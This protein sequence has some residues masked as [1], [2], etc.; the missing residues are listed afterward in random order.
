MKVSN[1]ILLIVSIY[2]I[3]SE[4]RKWYETLNY[5]DNEEEIPESIQHL[6]I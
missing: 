5:E 6:Y 2:L 3:S 4:I 1:K